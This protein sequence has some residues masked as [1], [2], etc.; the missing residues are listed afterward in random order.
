M[1]K[2]TKAGH[3]FVGFESSTDAVSLTHG[4]RVTGVARPQS[5]PTQ[6]GTGGGVKTYLAISQ[7]HMLLLAV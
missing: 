6:T 7:S 2:S 4:F 1:G 5:L 3:T